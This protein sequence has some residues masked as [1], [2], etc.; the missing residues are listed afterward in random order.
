MLKF[1]DQRNI[2]ITQN[3]YHIKYDEIMGTIHNIIARHKDPLE[4][5][6]MR[7]VIIPNSIFKKIEKVSISRKQTYKQKQYLLYIFSSS[8]I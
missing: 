4:M 3:L 1:W 2:S 6:Y 8:N 5:Q 7:Y